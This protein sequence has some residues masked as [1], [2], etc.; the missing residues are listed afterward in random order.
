[1]PIGP[2][3]D[4]PVG[5]DVCVV[6]SGPV[7]QTVARRLAARGMDVLVLEA[8]GPVASGAA[9]R[10]TSAVTPAIGDPYPNPIATHGVQVGGSAGRPEIRL[11]PSP[12]QPGTGIRLRAFDAVDLDPRP[13]V[14]LPGWP[15]DHATFRTAVDEAGRL[16]G[17]ERISDSPAVSVLDGVGLRSA[18]FHLAD[19]RCFSESPRNGWSAVRVLHG[20]P[21]ARLESGPDRRIHRAWVRTGDGREVA[22]SAEV[23][24]VAGAALGAARL[25]LSS[26]SA[27]SE[28]VANSSGLVGRNLMDHPIVTAGWLAP[29]RDLDPSALAA[30]APRTVGGH[31]V[32]PAL[33]SDPEMVR[34]DEVAQSWAT[35]VPRRSPARV[36]WLHCALTGPESERS[37]SPS[38]V[39]H[40]LDELRAGRRPPHLWRDLVSVAGGLDDLFGMWVRARAGYRPA[41][42]LEEPFAVEA[43]LRPDT[44]CLQILQVPEQLPDP[45]NRVVLTDQV[46]PVGRMVPRIWWRWS[47][48]D[49]RRERAFGRLVAGALEDAGLGRVIDPM[50]VRKRN[51]EKWSAHHLCGTARMSDGAAEGVVDRS[52][53]THDHPNLYITG[54]AVFPTCGYANPTINA[55]ATA[56]LAADAISSADPVTGVRPRPPSD[57]A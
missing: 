5:A 40:M 9:Q 55:M 22:V 3:G 31:F 10:L 29:R 42:S 57:D 49:R 4:G 6:G 19:R 17:I 37:R 28:G 20:A 46:D 8:G 2:I 11:D 52:C 21:V 56:V 45:E 23:F 50:T 30:F 7:G 48:D 32:W 16:F 13:A 53:R 34:N 39:R 47:R 27:D 35:L 36:A 41:W 1:M 25:L 24:V 12:M 33:I 15:I 38:A 44:P 14:G 26:A 54:A 51:I 43:G 18:G